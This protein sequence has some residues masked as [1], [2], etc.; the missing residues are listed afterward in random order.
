[1]ILSHASFLA[2][3]VLLLTLNKALLG[4]C[5]MF[6]IGLMVN[7]KKIKLCFDLASTICTSQIHVSHVCQQVCRKRCSRR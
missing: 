7:N 4:G 3:Y 5:P 2:R 1:M 6:T